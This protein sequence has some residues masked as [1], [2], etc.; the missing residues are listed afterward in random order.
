MTPYF[1]IKMQL[2]INNSSTIHD[3]SKSCSTM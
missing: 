1:T 3:Q 2:F